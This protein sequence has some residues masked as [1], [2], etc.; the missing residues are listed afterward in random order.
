[1]FQK[2]IN[3]LMR[4]LFSIKLACK[5]IKQAYYVGKNAP[6]Y[7]ISSALI[8]WSPLTGVSVD[9]SVMDEIDAFAKKMGILI[10]VEVMDDKTV[11]EFVSNAEGTLKSIGMISV[12]KEQSGL[13]CDSIVILPKNISKNIAFA[14]FE[15]DLHKTMSALTQHELRHIE[16]FIELRKNGYNIMD[17][18]VGKETGF[19][20]SADILEHDAYRAQLGQKRS[21]DEF[22]DE[23]KIEYGAA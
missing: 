23:V 19:F 14:D 5:T 3:R 6:S 1:M 10:N 18:L 20:Y 12:P 15:R 11:D 21:I 9:A 16:Q 8:C 4:K 13:D 2:I 22:M 7:S 17:F